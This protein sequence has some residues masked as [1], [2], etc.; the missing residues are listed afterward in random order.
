MTASPDTSTSATLPAPHRFSVRFKKWKRP[1]LAFV[2][3]QP[4]VQ[5]LNLLT[6]FLLLRWLGQGELAMFGVAFAFQTT[7]T[8][9]PIWVS[10]DPSSSWRAKA[11]E[12]TCRAQTAYL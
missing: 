5:L 11:A 4:A 10:P 7:V 3:G 1:L 6:G 9:S 12:P 2:L 8:N